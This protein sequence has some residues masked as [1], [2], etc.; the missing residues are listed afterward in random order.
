MKYLHIY[1]PG[2][3][4]Y[5]CLMR[6]GNVVKYGQHRFP[7]DHSTWKIAGLERIKAFNNLEF[8][9]LER[10]PELLKSGEPLKFKN[11]KPRFTVRDVDHGTARVWCNW[12]IRGVSKLWISDTIE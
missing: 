3:T 8:I 6:N 4:H 9:P 2:G 5:A 12:N 7:E 11:G 1:T 10:I